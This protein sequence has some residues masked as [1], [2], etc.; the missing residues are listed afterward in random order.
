MSLP[1]ISHLK[2]D[3]NNVWSNVVGVS[4]VV[5]TIACLYYRFVSHKYSAAI[6]HMVA[7]AINS[8]SAQF[9][10]GREST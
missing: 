2:S 1:A 10:S 9:V 6:N 3:H 5:S 4:V 8:A 7:V